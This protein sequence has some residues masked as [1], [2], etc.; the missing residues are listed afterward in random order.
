MVEAQRL[1]KEIE[2]PDDLNEEDWQRLEGFQWSI[3]TNP[4]T[5]MTAKDLRRLYYE[6]GTLVGATMLWHKGM[7]SWMPFARL[8]L[9]E[10][11]L[12]AE[13]VSSPSVQSRDDSRDIGI[14]KDELALLVV[15][16]SKARGKWAL[17]LQRASRSV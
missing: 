3:G 13:Q 1:P 12:P 5:P 6:E 17:N 16:R 10:R 2:L 7:S 14:D 8:V 4:Q 15:K 11:N 9:S